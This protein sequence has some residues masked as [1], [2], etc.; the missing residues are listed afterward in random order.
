[1]P[2]SPTILTRVTGVNVEYR[3]FNLGQALYLPQ[4]IAV[5]GQGSTS[6]TYPSAKKTVNG[7]RE[8]AELYGY[9]S[10]LHLAC[11]QLLP[12]NGNGIKGIP[13]TVYP[14][15]DDASGVA[16]TGSIDASG[17]ATAQGGGVVYVGGVRSANIVIPD[18]TAADAALAIIKTA[19]DAILHMPTTTGVVAAG[20]LPLTSKWEGE[21]SNDIT[22]DISE[23]E[24]EGLVF[25]TVAMAS[26]A[27]NPD[28]QDALDLIGEVW[29]T[30]IINCMNYDD[31]TTNATYSTFGESRREQTVKKP[32]Y[33]GTGCVDDFSTRTAVTDSA[34]NK[35][36]RTMF[37]VQSIGSRELPFVIVAQGFVNDIAQKANDKPAHNYIGILQG[38]HTGD[39]SV[40]EDITTR[41]NSMKLGASNNKKVGELAELNDTVLY[42]HPD[43]EDPPA[44][45]Y[46]VDEIKLQQI[47]YNLDIIQEAYKG[48]PLLPDTT[49]TVDPD[50]V[51]PKMV[52]ST[53]AKLADSLASGRSAI[54]ADPQFTKNN[55]TVEIDSINPKR[56]NTV[57]PVKLSGNVEVNSTDI[58]YSFYIGE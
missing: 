22:I 44:H 46:L 12:A 21:S 25:S 8:V 3:N 24:C 40:Q 16:S 31:T 5:I 38:L 29:E 18:T 10:P 55:M 37:L 51:Q 19:I 41:D 54:I 28:V 2:I 23:L 26:G 36:N 1:M 45:R 30:L 32:L 58:Y 57:F 53:L 7:E 49:P 39:D 20:S 34:A 4:R 15:T 48:R 11:R 52:R 17:A 50:A 42:Y 47:I 35:L 56:I 27:A 13:V 6:S 33:V 9:G 14:L 43:G